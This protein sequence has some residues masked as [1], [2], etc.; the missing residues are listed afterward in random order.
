MRVVSGLVGNLS[1]GVVAGITFSKA[2]G[3][4]GVAASTRWEG[5]A[6]DC[7][8]SSRQ[9]VY[10]MRGRFRGLAPSS[11]AIPTKVWLVA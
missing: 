9:V 8:V 11:R 7:F 3:R 6:A 4:R 2:A 1:I 5:G 10:V